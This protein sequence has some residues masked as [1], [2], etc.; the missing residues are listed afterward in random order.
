MPHTI[1]ILS[2]TTKNY[3]RRTIRREKSSLNAV[4]CNNSTTSSTKTSKTASRKRA[5]A[6]HNL[7]VNHSTPRG[8][9]LKSWQMRLTSHFFALCTIHTIRSGSTCLNCPFMVR[10]TSSVTILS[11]F[12]SN[13][14]STVRAVT[15]SA[16]S[17]CSLAQ[18][19]SSKRLHQVWRTRALQY[20]SCL[21]SAYS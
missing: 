15:F 3:C 21:T 9:L 11:V 12:S 6:P 7:S 17:F 4:I 1:R 18:A 2:E 16:T 5:A 14:T 19:T 10:T 13:A 20:Y 8:V